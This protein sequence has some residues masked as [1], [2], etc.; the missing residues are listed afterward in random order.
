MFQLEMANIVYEPFEADT[1]LADIQNWEEIINT[2]V[3]WNATQFP[4]ESRN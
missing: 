2:G 4:V 3:D 1:T